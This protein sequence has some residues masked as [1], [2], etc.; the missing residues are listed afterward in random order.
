LVRSVTKLIDDGYLAKID[1]DR[2]SK[3]DMIH[4][5]YFNIILL[6]AFSAFVTMLF[7]SV[8]TIESKVFPSGRLWT[9]E[10]TK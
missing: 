7:F 4:L 9:V 2:L 10:E 5:I 8:R 1:D 6:V 3:K